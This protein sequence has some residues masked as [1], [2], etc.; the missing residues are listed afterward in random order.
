MISSVL[1]FEKD[2]RV[3]FHSNNVREIRKDFKPGFYQFSL[4]SDGVICSTV[5]MNEI[6]TPYKSQTNDEIIK[7]VM[8]FFSSKKLKKQINMMGFPH[9]MGVLLYGNPGTGKTTLLNYISHL[10]FEQQNAIIMV[11]NNADSVEAS[12]AMAK[13]IR[14]IQTNPIVLILDE[15]ERFV[16]NSSQEARI[17]TFLDGSDSIDNCLTL[18]ATNYIDQ[19][20]ES[21]GKRQSRF[22]VLKEITGIDSAEEVAD[23]VNGMLDSA[24][25]AESFKREKLIESIGTGVT[26]D[27]IKNAV[28]DSLMGKKIKSD[29]GRN[30]I[31]FNRAAP[32]ESSIEDD[33]SD[34]VELLE[35]L[36]TGSPT[37]KKANTY[38]QLGTESSLD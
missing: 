13:S 24:Q 30:S 27:Y 20:P 18:A 2:H 31:G 3:I 11:C 33:A 14:E 6:H 21:I 36:F 29:S 4:D 10:L 26:L 32:D 1:Y 8:T 38:R 34:T 9:K 25:V 19:V 12:I 35:F 16:S 28:I 37:V 23:L 17:K 22:R 15:F 5:N 7:A